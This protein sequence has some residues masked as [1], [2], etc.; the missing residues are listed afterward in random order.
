M[1]SGVTLV[2]VERMEY[3]REEVRFAQGGWTSGTVVTGVVGDG[4][5]GVVVLPDDLVVTH[6]LLKRSRR[7][8]LRPDTQVVGDAATPLPAGGVRLSRGMRVVRGRTL[9]GRV[10]ALWCDRASGRVMHALV[11]QGGFV[12]RGPERVLAAEHVRELARNALVLAD[13]APA[14]DALPPYR[15]DKAITAE[16]RLALAEALTSP[17]A[18]RGVKA[19][20]ED[21][22][23]HLVGV[24]ETE[25]EVARARRA[26]ERIPGVRDLVMDLVSTET[27]ADRVE[28]RLTAVLAANDVMDTDP[29]SVRVL[30]EHGIVY[31]EGSAP[32][33]A[34]RAALERATLAVAGARVVMN[35]LT[36][37][38]A[39][40][41][42][43]VPVVAV[44]H[45]SKFVRPLGP[46]DTAD[47]DEARRLAAVEGLEATVKRR[48]TLSR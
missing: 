44:A 8:V 48:A 17:R 26:A 42:L 21:G 31:L 15:P 33:S 46:D 40:I 2:E 18:R 29:E 4:A 37:D 1:V 19:A 10:R 45:A 14:L 35:N 28:A 32:T 24:V 34:V 27:L 30:A 9:A 13:T 41:P 6:T 7:R 12:G 43:R 20:V 11:R 38:A 3:A 5:R 39:T 23:I 36:V 47:E 25:E 16:L 22:R